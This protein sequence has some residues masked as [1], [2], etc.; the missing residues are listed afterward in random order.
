MTGLLSVEA[1]SRA[2]AARPSLSTYAGSSSR[3][4]SSSGPTRSSSRP[5]S[6][7][8]RFLRD[9]RLHRFKVCTP[10]MLTACISIATFDVTGRVADHELYPAAPHDCPW[11]PRRFWCLNIRECAPRLFLLLSPLLTVMSAVHV[12]FSTQFTSMCLTSG[13]PSSSQEETCC[14][15]G[16]GEASAGCDREG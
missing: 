11:R 15:V 3:L 16:G 2:P 1:G 4:C 7:L 9:T 10:P 5:A 14:T 6:S 12:L 8:H 13:R